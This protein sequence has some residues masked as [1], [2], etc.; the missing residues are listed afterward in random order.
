MSTYVATAYRWGWTNNSWYL[1]YAGPDRTKAIALAS[2]ECSERGG[3]Y[4]CEVINTGEDGT[5][6]KFVA[7]FPSAYGEAR[8][9]K[10]ERLE[11]FA[12]IGHRA[13]DAS[14]GFISVQDECESQGVLKQVEVDPPDWLKEIIGRAK[15]MCEMMQGI[16]DKHNPPNIPK[17]SQ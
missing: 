17:E 15:E 5:S 12:S 9:H 16:H 3:K 4:G 8:C 1:I 14:D 10:N 2:Q 11:M 6:E 13:V 7:Y